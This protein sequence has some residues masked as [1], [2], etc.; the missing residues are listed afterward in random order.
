MCDQ[1]VSFK[2]ALLP[3]FEMRKI[4]M[5]VHC[6]MVVISMSYNMY[7]VCIENTVDSSVNVFSF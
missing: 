1:D 2:M 4:L 5:K 6:E 3:A 7:D